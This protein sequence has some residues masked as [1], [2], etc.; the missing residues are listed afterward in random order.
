MK[1]LVL[2]D[3]HGEFPKKFIKIIKK[4]K[5]DLIVSTGDYMTFSLRKT[6]FKH[7]YNTDLNLWNIVGKKK[8]KKS[9]IRDVIAGERVL[10]IMNKLGVPVITI[11]G[12]VD[13]TKWD[14]AVDN[15]YK[16]EIRKEF[17]WL[18]RDFF[19]P[20]IKKYK[21]IKNID[22]SSYKF[23]DF[24]FIGYPASSVPG[25]VKSKK[26]K[27]YKRI[28]DKLFKKHAKEK[29]I[30]VAHNGPYNTKID[31]IK[32]K[33]THKDIRGK[34]YGSKLARRIVESYQPIL[35]LVGH[36][37][38]SI[39][40]QKLGKTLIVNPGAAHEERGAIVDI[41]NSKKIK[42]KFIK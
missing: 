2:G 38:E 7:S 28:L 24:V 20:L 11:T 17:K 36:I 1:L 41:F 12:N 5:I 40:M 35:T 9:V 8:Y 37:H 6:F 27:K 15:S 3:F 14:D 19:T 25:K 32:S 31:I 29:V 30:F 26:Y 23:G 16:A 34:H 33:E 22:Y 18:D 10:K 4:N 39:G 21:W 42:V 13:K